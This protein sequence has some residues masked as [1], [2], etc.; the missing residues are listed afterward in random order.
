VTIPSFFNAAEEESPENARDSV[1]RKAAWRYDV[2]QSEKHSLQLIHSVAAISGRNS[3]W[4]LRPQLNIFHDFFLTFFLSDLY[5]PTMDIGVKRHKKAH[6][7]TTA[8]K[9]TPSGQTA[10]NV[11][12]IILP[13]GTVGTDGL[14]GR[15]F[16]KQFIVHID[17]ESELK[18]LLEK[19]TK[20]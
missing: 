4:P 8:E 13:S 1:K 16:L 17:D 3:S 6:L 19:R 11:Q 12:A 7:A 9:K 2:G 15:S 5:L 14:L 18:L 10:Q 20:R